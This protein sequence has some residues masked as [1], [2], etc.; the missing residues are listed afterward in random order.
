METLFKEVKSKS[1]EKLKGEFG[2]CELADYEGL[3]TND[4]VY[5]LNKREDRK[6]CPSLVF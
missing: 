3:E 1:Q 6:T 4:R 2:D 5:S